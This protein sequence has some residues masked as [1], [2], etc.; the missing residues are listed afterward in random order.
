MSGGPL[1][2][3]HTN[4][5][6]G[7][8]DE[9]TLPFLQERREEADLYFDSGD[10]IKAG[11]LAVPLRPEPYWDCLRRARCTASTLGNRESHVLKAA[12]AAKTAGMATPVVVANMATKDGQLVFP[13]SQIVDCKGMRVGVVGT[14]VAMVTSR[15]A[16]APASQYLWTD[17]VE[18][19]LAEGRKLRGEVDL[20]LLL[21]HVGHRIDVKLAEQGVFD[22]ILGGHSHTVL[23]EP[24]LHGTTWVVQGG[25]HARYV[26]IYEWN[27]ESRRLSGGLL[28]WLTTG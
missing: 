7:K 13:P 6:H 23:P 8:L 25:S 14:M 1:K 28:P 2:I 24:E 11:N 22:I 3:L 17:P 18:A 10:G 27:W 21:S 9:S 15:M 19:A 4:D 20:L 5:L 12:F 16:T 26:G